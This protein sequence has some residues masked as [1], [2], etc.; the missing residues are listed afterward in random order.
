LLSK[1]LTYLRTQSNKTQ[2]FI[3]KKIGIT[4]QALIKYEKGSSEPKASTLKRIAIFYDVTLDLLMTS[5]L[6]KRKEI[7]H[8]VLESKV[9]ILTVTTTNSLKEKIELVPFEAQAGYLQEFQKPS[10]I[11]KLPTFSLPKHHNGI[12]RAFEINGDSMPPIN[13]NSIAI[14]RYIESW[15]DI[16]PNK[17]YILVSKNEGIVFKR[18]YKDKN[19][20]NNLILSSDNKDYAPYSLHASELAEIWLFVSFIGFSD[21]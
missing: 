4:R 15:S 9:R 19:N 8:N 18:V 2:E 3:A 7:T 12:Y 13:N 6:A 16:L 17:R 14:G 11:S 20:V 21:E 5:N 1:N 10:Y